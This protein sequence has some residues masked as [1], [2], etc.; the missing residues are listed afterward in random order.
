M[1]QVTCALGQSGRLLALRCQ[2]HEVLGWHTPPAGFTFA[3]LDSGVKH[4]VGGARYGVVRCAAYMGRRIIRDHLATAGD[5]PARADYLCNITPA[6]YRVSLRHL[7]PVRL[8]GREFLER[9]GD[10]GDTATRVDPALAYPVRGATE[11][12]IYENHRVA[13]FIARLQQAGE[14]AA[15][16]RTDRSLAAMAAAGRLMYGSHRSYSRNCGLGSPETDLLVAL[17]KGEGRQAGLLG[18]KITGGGSGGTVAVLAQAPPDGDPAAPP[19]ALQ[20][21]AS[22]FARRVGRPPRLI[23]GSQPGAEQMPPLALTW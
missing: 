13:R 16:G 12:P 21:V 7:L 14:A 19:A 17:V 4:A 10:T 15:A 20:R 3:G 6:E 11:H 2:P 1:D 8:T 23:A 9:W 5:D 22:E 18:A